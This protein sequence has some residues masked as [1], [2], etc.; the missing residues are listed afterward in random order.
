MRKLT[1]LNLVYT[2][3]IVTAIM[4]LSAPGAQATPVYATSYGMLNGRSGSWDYCDSTYLPDPSHQAD[5]WY[6]PLSGGTGKLT[7]GF[8]ATQNYGDYGPVYS[9]T[10]Y[11]GWYQVDPTITFHFSG[12]TSIN[13]V[14]IS[15]ENYYQAF[16]PSEIDIAM[17]ATT[18]T[19]ALSQDSNLHPRTITWSNLGLSGSTLDL[20]LH[21][22]GYYS[23]VMVSEV[24]F[25][26]AP[27]PVPPTMLLLGSGLVGLVG[28]RRF[29]KG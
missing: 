17:G 4:S 16:L 14:S 5:V 11:V 21:S 24:Q 2:C 22:S 27:V 25:D 1:W 6:S 15:V 29:R 12:L 7:D 23:Y 18:K 28:W 20:T 13:A 8:I 19:F 9:P 3:L 10:P 26:G